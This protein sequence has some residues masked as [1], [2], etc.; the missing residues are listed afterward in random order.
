MLSLP[1]WFG[2]LKDGVHKGDSND[3]RVA[4]IRV[5]PDEIRYWC[6]TKGKIGRAVEIGV[7]A[8]TGQAATPGELRIITKQEVS[9]GL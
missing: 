5:I 9:V 4:L 8:L 2:D 7:G 3:P 6:V 1:A